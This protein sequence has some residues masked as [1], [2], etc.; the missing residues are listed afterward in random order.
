[1]TMHDLEPKEV[2]KY[3][4]EVSSVPR[5]SGFTEEIR[6]YLVKFAAEN[7]LYCK[8]DEVGNVI[9]RKAGKSGSTKSSI[10]FQGHMDMVCEKNSNINH[11]FRK[12]PIDVV[13][14]GD[15]VRANGTTLGG[16][17]GIGVAMAMALL[18][19][20]SIDRP[21]EALFTVDEETGLTGA[22]NLKP[23][24]LISD[25]MIN[26]DTEDDEE[27][28][29]GCAGGIDTSLWFDIEKEKVPYK[30]FSVKI[31]VSGLKGGHSGE[32]I[33]KP[34]VNANILLAE[35]LKRVIESGDADIRVAGINGGGLR[36]AIP[37]E[38]EACI[39]L[40]WS[41]KEGIRV[42]WNIYESE[43]E[44]KYSQIEPLMKLTLESVTPQEEAYSKSLTEAVV[45]TLCTLPHGVIEMNA[46]MPTMVEV[47]T[48]LA[49]VRESEGKVLI[50][51]S[52]RSPNLRKR[53]AIAERVAEVG[54]KNGATITNS[55]GYPGWE[56]KADSVLKDAAAETYRELFKSEP[57]VKSIH[58]G[59]EC[60]LF[61]KSYPDMDM[62]SVG[63]KITGVHSPDETLYISTVEKCWKFVKKLCD[64]LP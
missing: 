8:V 36:N 57:K 60:G 34:R 3:F 62:I 51:T 50:G 30:P 46:E 10:V 58:A 20:S 52:Q 19:D 56:P 27:I 43:C 41:Y 2:W 11:D 17:D 54:K 29:I 21:I 31:K 12:D 40:P 6:E 64:V 38:A 45:S 59:L 61:S 18:T 55:G 35:F 1:M 39:T 53:D 24:L 15:T 32:D 26:L 5:G 33:D 23:G 9:M 63:P 42:A 25:K 28:I 13:V 16:D 37:R 4:A 48:N 49:F 14:E 44:E 47:S 7:Q 22:L